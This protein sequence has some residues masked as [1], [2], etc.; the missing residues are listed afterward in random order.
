MNFILRDKK[1]SLDLNRLKKKTKSLNRNNLFKLEEIKY[2][3]LTRYNKKFWESKKLSQK[4]KI[5]NR[6]CLIRK[7]LSH[8]KKVN[9]QIYDKKF[10]EMNFEKEIKYD[11]RNI[12]RWFYDHFKKAFLKNDEIINLLE[13]KENN[14]FKKKSSKILDYIIQNQNDTENLGTKRNTFLKKNL[15]KRNLVKFKNFNKKIAITRE[16]LTREINKKILLNWIKVKLLK[17]KGIEKKRM[18]EIYSKAKLLFNDMISGF[19]ILK[20]FKDENIMKVCEIVKEVNTKTIKDLFKNHEDFKKDLNLF[21]KKIKKNYF[22]I[23]KKISIE[24]N[25]LDSLN[26]EFDKIKHEE[27]DQKENFIKIKRIFSKT[28]KDIWNL[29]NKK[30]GKSIHKMKIKDFM[31]INENKNIL[32]NLEEQYNLNTQKTDRKLYN[33]KIQIHGLKEIIKNLKIKKTWLSSKLIEFYKDL[34]RDEESLLHFG[35]SVILIVKN[36]WVLKGNV[37]DKNFSNFYRKEDISFI[38]KYSEFYK[39]KISFF[40][41][42]KDF[43]IKKKKEFE[44][45]YQNIV[46][47]NEKESIFKM[48]QTLRKIKNEKKLK[49]NFTVL[50]KNRAKKNFKTFIKKNKQDVNLENLKDNNYHLGKIKNDYINNIIKNRLLKN[51]N[52]K[53]IGFK[54]FEYF[55]KLIIII[56]GKNKK[57]LPLFILKN[58]NIKIMPN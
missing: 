23:L 28:E 17:I 8:I 48:R 3:Y 1:H 14:N 41:N 29:T 30:K 50:K 38:F 42:Q 56:F 15:V 52:D 2:K 10:G 43:K 35:K 32:I 37:I 21:E 34:L 26:R 51:F 19:R 49:V 44:N 7:Q 57:N 31:K 9:I 39:K 55:E 27:K 18:N 46:N 4:E 58:E 36:I 40:K 13:E 45:F 6:F 47:E 20:I 11:I 16:T 25:K 22:L 24:K 33:L 5:Q 12:D 54:E 53:I